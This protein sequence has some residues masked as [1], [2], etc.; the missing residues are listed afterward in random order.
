M[1]TYKRILVG[2]DGSNEA[3]A[4]LRRAIRIA[5]TNEAVLGIGF[6]AD[7]RRIAPLIDYEQTYAKKAKAYGEELIEIYANEAKHA[8]I[9]QV[10]TFVHFGTPKATMVHKIAKEFKADLIIV[11]ATGLTATEQMLIGSVT[12]YIARHAPCDVIIVHGKSWN[13]RKDI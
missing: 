13:E 5:K 4:A 8:G 7:L 10:E 6:V 1:T 9:K 2:I 3:E 11:G 12:E